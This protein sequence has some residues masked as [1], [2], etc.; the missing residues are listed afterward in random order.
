[1]QFIFDNLIAMMVTGVIILILATNYQSSRRESIDTTAYYSLNRSVSS[2][3]E[4]V[5]RDLRCLSGVVSLSEVDSSFQFFARVSPG[6]STE[7]LV[8]YRR[9]LGE[10]YDGVQTFRISRLVDGQPDGETAFE[11][12]D[13]QLQILDDD[14]LPATGPE[15]AD[16]V[17]F[18]FE[19]MTPL[20][21]T[22][23][24]TPSDDVNSRFEAVIHPPILNPLF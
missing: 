1:M 20:A 10:L 17:H 12:T 14:G 11:L 9:T 3:K 23:A 8:E 2:F 4:V 13:W 7:H 21:L 24:S 18:A 22:S 19:A 16:R 5:N 15:N 6:G